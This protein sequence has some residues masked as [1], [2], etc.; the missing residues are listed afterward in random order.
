MSEKNKVTPEERLELLKKKQLE[1]DE[2]AQKAKEAVARLQK[3][4]AEKKAK[5]Q[6]A[7]DDGYRK[8]IINIFNKYGA[9]SVSCLEI[10]AWLKSK[11]FDLVIAKKD[12]KAPGNSEKTQKS[13]PIESEEELF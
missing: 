7:L 2:A 12:S 13:T 8:G 11:G 5:A 1:R 10:E 3:E 4:I 9:L 6:K